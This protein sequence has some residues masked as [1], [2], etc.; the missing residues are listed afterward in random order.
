MDV[1]KSKRAAQ[2][3]AV[4]QYLEQEVPLT[5]PITD[6]DDVEE[7]A[8]KLS[9]GELKAEQVV[10]AYMVDNSCFPSNILSSTT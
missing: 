1:V 2:F 3:A 4:E 9:T 5:D 6:I 7:L 10:L 8:T